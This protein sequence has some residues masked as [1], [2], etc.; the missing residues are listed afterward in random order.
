LTDDTVGW[1]AGYTGNTISLGVTSWTTNQIVLSGFGGE[2]GSGNLSLNVGDTFT[3]GVLNP[4]TGL[5]P[6]IYTSIV[7]APLSISSVSAIHGKH[8]Q[9]I[10]I[11]GSGFGTNNP[12]DGDS[13]YIDFKDDTV[14]WQAGYQGNTITL[15]VTS[16]TP[17]QIVLSGFGGEYGS[18]NF[19][20]NTGDTFTLGVLNPQTE[21]GPA[22]YTNTVA[23]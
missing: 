15:G 20:L 19:S 2:Y 6:A 18:G 16:W 9:T 13:D 1:Q 5:G 4:Q 3:I 21:L 22:T 8:T 10:T 23:Q 7:Q 14:G 12:Y 17:D 11:T